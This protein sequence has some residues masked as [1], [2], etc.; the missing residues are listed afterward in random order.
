MGEVIQFTADEQTRY[1]L[2]D[3]RI[4]E[5][6]YSGAMHVLLDM[7]QKGDS[8]ALYEAGRLYYDTE[9]FEFALNCFFKYLESAGKNGQCKAYNGIAGC[10]Y[11]IDNKTIASYYYDRQ[12]SISKSLECD[13]EDDMYDFFEDY[14]EEREEQ[15][16][17]YLVDDDFL[18][19]KKL[20]KAKLF[21][22]EEKYQEAEDLLSEISP[23]SKFY[24]QAKANGAICEFINGK[25]DVATDKLRKLYQENPENGYVLENLINM[26]FSLGKQSDAEDLAG[27]L[28]ERNSDD[29]EELLRM[30]AVLCNVGNDEFI[31][32]K[33]K[34]LLNL[35]PYYLSGIYLLGVAQFNTGRIKDSVKTFKEHYSF[36][37][38][39]VTKKLFDIAESVANGEV[40]KEK[41]GKMSYVFGLTDKLSKDYA[42]Q[43]ETLSAM[44]DKQLKRVNK[45]EIEKLKNWVFSVNLPTLQMAVSAIMLRK[46]GRK[47]QEYLASVL[48]RVDIQEEIKLYIV[49][50]LI[51]SGYGKE[52]AFTFSEIYVKL[53]FFKVEFGEKLKEEF[54][55]A[56]ALAYGR[57]CAFVNNSALRKLRNVALDFYDKLV[58][59]GRTKKIKDFKALAVAMIVQAGINP[60][61]SKKTLA[62]YFNVEEANV[63]EMLARYHI[64]E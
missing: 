11:N 48:S 35:K 43:I 9:N 7:A 45:E 6:D 12:L 38:S 54:I 55:D 37:H 57:V 47:N 20:E 21:M 56:Y 33:V 22:A 25:T 4:E 31:Y 23:K 61:K 15:K 16:K 18:A 29:P 50:L 30:V 64:K 53:R 44:S 40:P 63:D 32:R 10:F 59:N 58:E 17:F 36:T 51:K 24:F 13:F 8:Q 2:T 62:K 42:E 46:G 60:T 34:E 49:S 3:K 27:I 19:E 28:V 14:K 39:Y 26:L 1:A 52:K 5:G 41:I